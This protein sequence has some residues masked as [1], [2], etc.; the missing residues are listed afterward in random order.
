MITTSKDSPAAIN[1]FLHVPGTDGL[2]RIPSSPFS[3]LSSPLRSILLPAVLREPLRR[4]NRPPGLKDESLDSFMTR[5]FG[6][7][8]ARTFGSALVHGIYAA[9][10][11]RL[12]VRAAFP[13]LWDAEERGW[14][15]V[16][17]GLIRPARRDGHV[18]D[19]YELGDMSERMRGVSVYSFR[20]GMST[21]TSALENHLTAR[22]N[23]RLLRDTNVVSIEINEDKSLKVPIHPPIAKLPTDINLQVSLSSEPPLTPTHIVSTLSLPTLSTLLPGSHPLPHLTANPYSSVTVLNLIFP[24]AP[25]AIHPPGFGYLIPRPQSDYPSLSATPGILGTVFDSC[26]LNAQDTPDAKVTKLTVMIGGPHLPLSSPSP[27]VHIPTILKLL[28]GHLQRELPAPIYSRVWRN[29]ACIPTPLPGHL[30]RM[31]ELRTVL[32]GTGWEGR[33]KVVGAGV[34]G[35]SVG[36]C[37]EAGRKVGEDW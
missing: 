30:E 12:S 4:S 15:S 11:R 33:M 34:G 10:A 28:S 1:R 14:G 17:R 31:G 32:A 29:D 27:D 35:V 24:G 25:S 18:K 7:P 21:L 37:I 19:D 20:D 23:V 16:V 5:R 22:A 26:A 8:F 3:V 2:V 36:D 6:E 9:D 13:T